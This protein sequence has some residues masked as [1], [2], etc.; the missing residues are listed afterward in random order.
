ME[1][2]LFVLDSLAIFFFFCKKEKKNYLEMEQISG[3][4]RA[5]HHLCLLYLHR[6]DILWQLASVCWF[7]N[8]SII[9]WAIFSTGTGMIL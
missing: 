9:C 8:F 6:L 5:R 7:V 4:S 3:P 1:D 2:T